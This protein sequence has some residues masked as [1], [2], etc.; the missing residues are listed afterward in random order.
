MASGL[1]VWDAGATLIFDE[2]TPVTKFLGTVTIGEGY[3]GADQSGSIVDARFTQYAQ[4]VGFWCRIDGGFSIDGFD[5]TWRFDGNSLIWTYPRPV[6]YYTINGTTYMFNR[7]R[8]T[9]IYGIR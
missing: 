3:T 2:T 7:P 5:P 1:Q 8:V 9:I 4:H 6:Q